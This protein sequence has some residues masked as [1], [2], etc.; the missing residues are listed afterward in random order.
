MHGYYDVHK[1]FPPPA[2]CDPAGK[3][4]LSWRVALLPFIEQEPLYKRFNLDEPWDSPHNHTLIGEM[5]D[6]FAA[7]HRPEVAPGNTVYQVFVGPGTAF[8]L[9]QPLRLPP[10]DFPGGPRD[11]FLIV[12]AAEPVPWTKPEDLQYAPDRALPPLGSVRKHGRPV[13]FVPTPMRWMAAVDAG[14]AGHGIDLD[15][16]DDETLRRFIALSPENE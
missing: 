12:E 3:P 9:K 6:I 8:D 15:T 11:L 13:L 14:G 4:L 5:P 2:L 1:H 7:P 16:T 10:H